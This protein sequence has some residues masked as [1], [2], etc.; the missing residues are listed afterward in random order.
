MLDGF[1]R[2]R[3]GGECKILRTKNGKPYINAPLFFS[4]AHSGRRAVIAVCD[5]PV[6]VD[7]ELYKKKSRYA[8]SSRFSLRERGEIKSE[9][10][11]LKHWT[12]RE[13]FVKAIGGTLFSYLKGL[14]FFG[15]DLYLDGRKQDVKI[16]FYYFSFGVAAL[17]CGDLEI[18]VP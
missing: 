15:G 17:C 7:L 6:G 16:R 8:V 12:V 2:A 3:T 11:F 9:R 13:A 14:E 1:L 18:I 10:D 4:L 5:K